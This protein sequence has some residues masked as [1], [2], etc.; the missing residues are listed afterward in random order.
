MEITSK[1]ATL[2]LILLSRGMYA[3]TVEMVVMPLGAGVLCEKGYIPC[4]PTVP[5]SIVVSFNTLSP[6][7]VR[8][9]VEMVDG[10]KVVRWG[11]NTPSPHENQPT[12]SF[13]TLEIT[14]DHKKFRR[15]RKI[16]VFA[17]GVPPTLLHNDENAGFGRYTYIQAH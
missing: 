14:P 12:S 5:Q 2:V 3:Q 6:M 13:V 15:L 1:I 7:V 16:A 8:V 9:E 4:P 11:T 17:D 10:S